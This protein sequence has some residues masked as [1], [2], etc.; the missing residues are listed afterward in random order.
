MLLSFICGSNLSFCL[1]AIIHFVRVMNELRP[2]YQPPS[3]KIV[4]SSLLDLVYNKNEDKVLQKMK[5]KRAVIM[6]DW[7]TTNQSEAVIAHAIY[8]GG[9]VQ[10]LD[11]EVMNEVKKTAENCLNLLERT[12][13]MA[14][15]KYKIQFIG[16][17]TDNCNTMNDTY[18]N[19][20]FA[21]KN[22]NCPH[23]FT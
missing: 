14:E 22:R 20:S 23:I 5:V 19:A 16:Y 9:E 13:N 21:L 1:F 4:S 10:F 17:V 6:Q 3:A 2:S 15:K 8:A 12:I 18:C 7:W 11:T